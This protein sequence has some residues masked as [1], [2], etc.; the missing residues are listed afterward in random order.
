MDEKI[1]ANLRDAGCDEELI[2][3]YAA[4][5]S[6]CARICLLKERRRELLDGIHAEQ[7][8]LECLDYLI[9]QLRGICSC[10][11]RNGSKEEAS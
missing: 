1:L 10:A 2:A 9:C 8:R 4:A 6:D 7:R 11:C 3:E 5:Q